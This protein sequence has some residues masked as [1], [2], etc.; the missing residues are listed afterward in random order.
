[1]EI[2]EYLEQ[3]NFPEELRLYLE[4]LRNGRDYSAF[5]DLAK[6]G[7]AT[8]QVTLGDR[9]RVSISRVEVHD[10]ELTEE[11][12]SVKTELE[13]AQKTVKEQRK[14]ITSLEKKATKKA[15]KKVTVLPYSEM[16]QDEDS[17]P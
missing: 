12:N 7:T 1:M 9:N 4:R 15:T 5:Q 6:K 3:H 16:P 2:A 13:E 11:L 8:V 10:E 14:E 17:K